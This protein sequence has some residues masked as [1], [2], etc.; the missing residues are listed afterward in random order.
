MKVTE[1]IEER[2]MDELFLAYAKL[3]GAERAER[4]LAKAVTA[5][6]GVLGRSR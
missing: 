3:F 1:M 2:R 4:P 5:W 6:H